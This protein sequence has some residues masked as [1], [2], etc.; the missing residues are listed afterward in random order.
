[1]VELGD[2]GQAGCTRGGRGRFAAA[3]GSF[4]GEMTFFFAHG[5]L[6]K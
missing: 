6:G 3:R 1:V 5:F 2:D 4:D